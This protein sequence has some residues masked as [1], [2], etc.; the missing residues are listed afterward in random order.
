M[1]RK[2]KTNL[3]QKIISIPIIIVTLLGFIIPNYSRANFLTD[4]LET[5]GKGFLEIIIMIPDAIITLLQT[6]MIDWPEDQPII[7]EVDESTRGIIFDTVKSVPIVGEVLGTGASKITFV[8][9][10]DKSDNIFLT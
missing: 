6:K 7:D 2:K 9:R 4:P 3:K 1:G 5:I 8:R 10:C